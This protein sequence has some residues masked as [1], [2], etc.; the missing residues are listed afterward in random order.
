MSTQLKDTVGKTHPQKGIGSKIHGESENVM[1]DISELPQEK[2]IKEEENL[3]QSPTKKQRREHRKMRGLVWSEKDQIKVDELP[4]PEML[5]PKD[6]SELPHA[7][8]LKVVTS[9]ICGSDRHLIH[10]RTIGEK[11][12]LLGHEITGQVVEVG[13][14]VRNIKDGDIVSVPFNISCGTCRNCV[15]LNTSACLRVNDLMPG[16]IYGYAGMGDWQGGL[17]EY[18]MVPF[19]DFNLLVL[20]S[21]HKDFWNKIEDI[22]LITDVLPTALHGAISGGVE[23]G[24]IVFIC[25]AGPVGLSCAKLCFS[26]GAAVVMMA[27]RHTEKLEKA[28]SIGC[29]V[30]NIKEQKQDDIVNEVKKLVGEEEVDIGIDCVG[31]E[32]KEVGKKTGEHPSSALDLLIALVRTNGNISV[33]GAYLIPDPKAVDKDAEEGAYKLLFGK[34]WNKRISIVGTGQCPVKRYNRKLMMSI[35]HDRLSVAKLLNTKIISLDE[36]PKEFQKFNKGQNIKLIIDPHGTIH[37]KT[38]T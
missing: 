24:S 20:P 3:A 10:G 1:K 26:L 36:A 15:E 17:A 9:C 5:H 21:E 8:I 28:K 19:A 27:D 33:P 25:G 12:T 31:Y 13:S 38:S 30:F 2:E 29:H 14:S 11:G 6:G 16:G 18:L 7:V 32:A 34:A 35:L 23:I 4:Y 37:A 22:A